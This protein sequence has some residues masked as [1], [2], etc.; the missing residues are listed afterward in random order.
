MGSREARIAHYGSDGK[1]QG[2]IGIQALERDDRDMPISWLVDY[3]DIGQEVDFG[4]DPG[5][6]SEIQ[7]L[8]DD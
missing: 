6:Y 1:F 2:Y 4:D 8:V 7:D 3:S 5:L